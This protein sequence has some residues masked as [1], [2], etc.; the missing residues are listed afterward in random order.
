M[1]NH[2]AVSRAKFWISRSIGGTVAGAIGATLS[3]ACV[4]IG[5]PTGQA[6][7]AQCILDYDECIN[8]GVGAEIC[9]AIHDECSGDGEDSDG[10]TGGPDPTGGCWDEVQNCLEESN[11]NEQECADLIQ[12]CEGGDDGDD[13]DEPPNDEDGQ[14]CWDEVEQCYET[15]ADHAECEGLAEMCGADGGDGPAVDPCQEA[16][17]DCLEM[18]GDEQECYAEVPGCCS[19]DDPACNPAPNDCEERYG[20]CVDSGQSEDECHAEF[21]QCLDGPDPTGEPPQ[22]D[23][24]CDDILEHCYQNQEL[25]DVCGSISE[26]CI[27]GEATECTNQFFDCAQ[28]EP[29]EQWEAP[30]DCYT[31]LEQCLG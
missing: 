19:P 27:D 6:D 18:G 17:Q 5:D 4:L 24:V 8:L 30:A 29:G 23:Y 3:T 2:T 25:A 7:N 1:S 26:R 15:N 11:G 31:Q 13:G 28:V 22:P 21:E 10:Q 16:V 20:Q 12:Q 9:Q 14:T